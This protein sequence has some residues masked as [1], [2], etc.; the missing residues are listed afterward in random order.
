[1]TLTPIRSSDP[2][3][4]FLGFSIQVRACLSGAPLLP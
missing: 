3:F 1:M 4:F 2:V